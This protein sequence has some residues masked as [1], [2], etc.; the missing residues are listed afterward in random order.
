MPERILAA[1]RQT[2]DYALWGTGLGVIAGAISG[3][4]S[5][6]LGAICAGVGVG[7]YGFARGAHRLAE[8]YTKYQEGRA[9]RLMCKGEYVKRLQQ[10]VCYNADGCLDRKTEP[11]EA[12]I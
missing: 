12:G 8:T 11:D 4:S 2:G 3:H 5:Y 9:I 7:F 1:L 6:D 10:F